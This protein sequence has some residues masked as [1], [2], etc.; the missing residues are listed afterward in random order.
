LQQIA[1][2]QHRL[3][4]RDLGVGAQ[5][6]DAVEARL[7]GQFAGIDLEGRARLVIPLGVR[8]R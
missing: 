5:H 2:A 6:K 3:Q 1:I 4:R 8:R 7:L